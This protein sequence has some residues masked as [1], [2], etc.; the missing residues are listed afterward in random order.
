MRVVITPL[1][2]LARCLTLAP[3]KRKLD[4]TGPGRTGITALAR[5]PIKEDHEEGARRDDRD[6]C[7]WGFDPGDGACPSLG[8]PS[9]LRLSV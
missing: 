2:G 9:P 4:P 1:L 6:Y 5:V 3:R 7:R 8:M